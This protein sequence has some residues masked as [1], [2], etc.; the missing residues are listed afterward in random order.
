[1]KTIYG[2]IGDPV[3]HSLSPAMHSAVF[4]H[5]GMDCAYHS[6]RVKKEYL[7]EAVMG[8]R[9]LGFGGLNVTIPHKEGVLKFMEPDPFARDIGAANTLDFK[10]MIAFN[11]DGPG[12]LDSLT[13]NGVK[14][15]DSNILVLGAGGS[16]R[17][18]VYALAVNGA[19]VTV[20]NRTEDKAI[21]LASYMSRF[22]NVRSTG[23]GNIK[24]KVRTSNVI[25]NTT[26]VGMVP[27]AGSTL[28]TGDMLDSS[29]VVF[30]L[31]YKPLETRLLKEARAAGAKTIDGL[32]MLAR[33]GARSFEIWTGVKPPVRIM[34]KAARDAL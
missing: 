9:H 33:Q 18:I 5:L 17:A 34:E 6:F 10:R 11:T 19:D 31:V 15:E 2:V 13:D 26:S 30:D 3:G 23:L 24:E 4:A 25:I 28:V 8:A 1:M 12:A 22:G 20:A 32:T 27:D 29:Q 21:E 16:S 14:V 7:K